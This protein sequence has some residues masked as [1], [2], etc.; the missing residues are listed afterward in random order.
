MHREYVENVI[1]TRAGHDRYY[2]MNLLMLPG[3]TVFVGDTYV[4]Y[5]PSAEQLADMALLA[6]EEFAISAFNPKWRCCRTQPSV[7]RTHDFNQDGV[8]SRNGKNRTLSLA[9]HSERPELALADLL[10]L[11][12]DVIAGQVDVLPAQRRKMR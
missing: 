1:G 3:R 12:P 6:A 10:V 2:A 11:P 9:R 7:R 5:D 8:S 4:N